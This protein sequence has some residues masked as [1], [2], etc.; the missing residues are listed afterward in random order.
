MVFISIILR[1]NNFSTV[2]IG[3]RLAVS[4]TVN[5][6]S[7]GK[8]LYCTANAIVCS[9][10]INVFVICMLHLRRECVCCCVQITEI[11]FLIGLAA[12]FD[13]VANLV[14]IIGKVKV[15]LGSCIA[16]ANRNFF[17]VKGNR[18]LNGGAFRRGI[19][20]TANKAGNLYLIGTGEATV[21]HA[22]VNNVLVVGVEVTNDTAHVNRSTF[23]FVYSDRTT[24]HAVFNRRTG[25]IGAAVTNNTADLHSACTVN[26]QGQRT[27]KDRVFDQNSSAACV[28]PA[29]KTCKTC[30]FTGPSKRVITGIFAV[31]HGE[32]AF[33]VANKTARVHVA[34]LSGDVN[35]R[36]HIFQGRT[37]NRTP[38][39]GRCFLCYAIGISIINRTIQGHVLY[40]TA[41]KH[42]EHSV[43]DARNAVSRTIKN[44]AVIGC[45]IGR[46]AVLQ[47]DR[48]QKLDI[49]I[50]RH[51][52]KRHDQFIRR[53]DH[54]GAASRRC[55]V[56]YY[57]GRCV[58]RPTAFIE[59]ISYTTNGIRSNFFLI[60]GNRTVI[61]SFV[62]SGALFSAN[63][64]LCTIR[65]QRTHVTAMNV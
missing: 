61:G 13:R 57:F 37:R 43:I 23:G 20:Q 12:H 47:R 10:V 53:G 17:I 46:H 55:D 65:K 2:S 49:G 4:F 8:G 5:R 38:C 6:P 56:K 19:F 25:R 62:G 16:K 41:R 44:T 24:V 36:Y 31:C 52:G 33:Y 51:G 60:R 29:N 26:C 1:N 3:Y 14:N 27:A 42:L 18:I 35:V 34:C 15:G 45:S 58:F 32:G 39:D 22:R 21:V 54:V 7:N 9:G 50:A 64:I 30:I 63:K 59:V 48:F 11:I 28:D 40:R